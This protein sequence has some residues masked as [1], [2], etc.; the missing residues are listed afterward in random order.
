[1]TLDEPFVVPQKMATIRIPREKL[2]LVN[3][4]LVDIWV[5]RNDSKGTATLHIYED[6]NGF[7]RND[8]VI[9]IQ[10]DRNIVEPIIRAVMAVILGRSE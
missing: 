5:P 1:M 7:A 8:K 9:R 3:D 4:A 6:E 2:G 10:G